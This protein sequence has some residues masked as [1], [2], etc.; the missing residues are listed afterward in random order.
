MS[1]CLKKSSY[2]L[3]FVSTAKECLNKL[4][5]QNVDIVIVGVKIP[6]MSCYELCR[7]IKDCENT[8]RIKIMMISSAT[9]AH[10]KVK[11]YKSGVD[12]YICQPFSED[13]LLAKIRV[14]SESIKIEEDLVKNNE[15]L[16]KVVHMRSEQL[17]KNCKL[18]TLGQVSS[19]IA[20]D[21]RNPLTAITG[22]V[23]LLDELI[24]DR[25]ADD[26]G[27]KAQMRKFA[28]T[29]RSSGKMIENI[30][31]SLKVYSRDGSND[32]FYKSSIKEAVQNAVELCHFHI[33]H[34]SI[35]LEVDDVPD[36]LFSECRLTQICQVL[37]NLLNNAIDAT[38]DLIEKWIKIE[39]EDLGESV[40]IS[41]TDSGAGIDK[42]IGEKILLPF[43]S[44][45]DPHRGTGLGL[46]ISK[47]ILVEHN[48]R[49]YIDFNCPNTR[50]VMEF[51]KWH[52]NTAFCEV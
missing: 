3:S 22:F 10:D 32:P 20:H 16:E 50:F 42:E 13:E 9:E 37:V 30:L 14:F 18:A 36:D 24:I 26:D 8:K 2:K 25:V 6:D 5:V 4:D 43:F 27:T 44:T 21:I 7:L 17:L 34:K 19:E 48:G 11:G 33:T 45:K 41:V 40:K 46:S 35:H 47:A 38:D 23:E 49:F 15:E 12:D 31:N 39:V 29:I 28:G 52:Y 1:D 51:P